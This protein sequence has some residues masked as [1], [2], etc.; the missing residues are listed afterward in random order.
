MLLGLL[1]CH[2][3]CS[4]CLSAQDL[5]LSVQ[6]QISQMQ[7]EPLALKVSTEA[8]C[9]HS[10]GSSHKLE[11]DKMNISWGVNGFAGCKT[12]K[13]RLVSEQCQAIQ[14]H[15]IVFC[16]AASHL[17]P[18]RVIPP[19]VQR[20]WGSVWA[21]T[22]SEL[23]WVPM[24]CVQHLGHV[25]TSISWLSCDHVALEEASFSLD[26]SPWGWLHLD[27]VL[28]SGPCHPGSQGPPGCTLRE[29]G[30]SCLGWSCLPSC[31]LQQLWLFITF[32]CLAGLFYTR[33]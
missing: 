7:T 26:H 22:G 16:L 18:M 12:V 11:G 9:I 20:G 5:A 25:S 14:G 1:E 10:A 29:D 3:Y 23:P 13:L 31:P 4:Q 19:R 33:F 30:E 15:G 8:F 17:P 6:V 21:P 24:A 32:L 28:W 27:A 2:Q